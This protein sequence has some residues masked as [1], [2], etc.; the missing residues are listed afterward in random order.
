MKYSPQQ[1]QFFDLAVSG[2]SVAAPACAGAGKSSTVRPAMNELVK[3]GIPCM[4]VP[5]MNS[6]YNEEL[7]AMPQVDVLNAHKRGNRMQIGKPLFNNKKVAQIADAIDGKHAEIIAEFCQKLKCESFGISNFDAEGIGTKYGLNLDFTDSAVQ[8][9]AI[10]DRNANSI[11]FDDQLRFPVLNGLKRPF[12]GTL[13]VDEAQD[14][15]PMMRDFLSLFIGPETKGLILGDKDRQA[16]QQFAGADPETFSLLAE[17]LKCQVIP[18]TYNFRCGKSIVDNAN[19]FYPS[20]M[21]AAP[22]AIEG[23]VGEAI[24]SQLEELDS[25]SAILCEMNS[26]LLSFVITQIEKDRPVQFRP[27]KLW[28]KCKSVMWGLFDVRRCPVGEI[29]NR[30]EEKVMEYAGDSGPDP[31]KLESIKCISLLENLCI[32][33][34][35]TTTKWN[36]KT[37]VHPL[38]QILDFLSS[39]NTGPVCM[40]GHT[41]KGLQW[42]NVYHIPKV[43]AP[44]PDKPQQPWEVHQ[45]RCVG[46]VIRTRAKARHFTLQ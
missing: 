43:P 14:Y 7:T 21:E 27:G 29:A 46:Y 32:A 22:D 9:L 38:E 30:A 2:H 23:E 20:D 41:S 45:W 33:K 35:I 34:G 37:P 4:S 11:D 5:F 39:G 17:M 36:H 18:F 28:D 19:E 44:R 10:S 12:K 26:P 13:L 15:S 42:E 6:L 31:D 16:L 25:N 40:T 3:R 8:C 1:Q 24:T